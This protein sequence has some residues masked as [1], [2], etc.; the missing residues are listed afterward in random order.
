MVDTWS[1]QASQLNETTKI[2]LKQLHVELQM[3]PW[4]LILRIRIRWYSFTWT[5]AVSEL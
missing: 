4:I 2:K 1:P 3:K 5:F